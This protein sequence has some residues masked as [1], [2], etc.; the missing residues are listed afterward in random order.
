MEYIHVCPLKAFH[1]GSQSATQSISMKFK[2]KGNLAVV[3]LPPTVSWAPTD[4]IRGGLL[5]KHGSC[6]YEALEGQ[7][8]SDQFVTHLSSSGQIKFHS[9]RQ[10]GHK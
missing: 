6:S 9:L 1:L 5:R 2:Y 3:Q 4:Q 8:L 7:Q 10:K